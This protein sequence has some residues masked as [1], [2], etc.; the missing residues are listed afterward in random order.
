MRINGPLNLKFCS[1]LQKRVHILSNLNCF[2]LK[3][4]YYYIFKTKLLVEAQGFI[5]Y[6]GYLCKENPGHSPLYVS[7]TWQMLSY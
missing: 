6:T 3:L 4:N 1:L 7:D 5:R 2:F